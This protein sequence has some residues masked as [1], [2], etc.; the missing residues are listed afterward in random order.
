MVSCAQVGN[1]RLL[2]CFQGV[3][4]GYQPAAGCQ[5]APLLLHNSRSWENQVALGGS[6]CPTNVVVLRAHDAGRLA[7]AAVAALAALAVCV[8]LRRPIGARHLALVEGDQDRKSTRLNSS[9]L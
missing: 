7:Q 8:V 4:A 3:P 6:A 1:R 9:H 5:P 2:A